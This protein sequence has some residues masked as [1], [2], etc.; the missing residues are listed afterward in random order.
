[1]SR[2]RHVRLGELV[3]LA[4]AVCIA[5][6]LALPWYGGALRASGADAAGR[7]SAWST[8]GPTIV[9]L[10]IGATVAV[11]LVLANLFERT[12]AAPVAAAVWTTFFGLVASIC[13]L[14]RVLER[15]DGAT[16]LQDGA[17]LA[18]AGALATLAGGWLSIRDERPSLYE[19]LGPIAPRKPP[20]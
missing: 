20:V 16:G 17:W 9:F 11:A 12:P 2:L 19:S 3:A 4:G 6:A 15:P 10:L 1:M 8:F 13:A 7:L 18:L 5:V 14:I